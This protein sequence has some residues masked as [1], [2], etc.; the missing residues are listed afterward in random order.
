MNCFGVAV[1]SVLN[2]K[3]HQKRDDRGAVLMINCQ[4]SE[5]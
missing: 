4:V 3:Y 5:K 2:Q 1:L